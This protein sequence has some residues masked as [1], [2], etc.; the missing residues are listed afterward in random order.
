M[1]KRTKQ[2]I[3]KR[4][5]RLR[6]IIILGVLIYGISVFLNQQNMIKELN[7]EKAHKEKQIQLLNDELIE[8]EG[9]IQY[10]YTLDYIEKIAREELG[11]VKPGETIYIDKNKNKFVKGIKD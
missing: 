5:F 11:M 6:H 3:K 9:I 7:E 10:A 2:R 8:I 4:R 1:N